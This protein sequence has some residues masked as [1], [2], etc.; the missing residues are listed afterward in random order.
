MTSYIVEY[1]RL[2]FGLL[3]CLFALAAWSTCSTGVKMED[4][5]T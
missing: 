1:Y 3:V 5:Q 2:K 4:F